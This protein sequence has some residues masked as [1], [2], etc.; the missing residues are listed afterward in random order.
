MTMT[1]TNPTIIPRWEWRT[2]GD[3]FRTADAVFARFEPSG[4]QDSDELYLVAPGDNNV[5]IRDDLMDIKVLREVDSN[6]LERWEPIM[7]ASF[8]LQPDDVGTVM[9]ALGL[10]VPEPATPM[11]REAFR[12]YLRATGVGIVRPV[13]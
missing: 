3:G 2:F 8:P 1:A 13:E 7:K 5:K 6:G 10:P 9:G 12:D 4:I 11:S